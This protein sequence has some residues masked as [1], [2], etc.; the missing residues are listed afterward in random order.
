MINKELKAELFMLQTTSIERLSTGKAPHVFYVKPM[1][2]QRI[3][4][5]VLKFDAQQDNLVSIVI[6]NTHPA[7]NTQGGVFINPNKQAAVSSAHQYNQ[8]HAFGLCSQ[9]QPLTSSFD[10]NISNCFFMDWRL[11]CFTSLPTFLKWSCRGN[12]AYA[13]ISCT[14]L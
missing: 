9:S 14:D 12:K 3:T 13:D 7:V 2:A 6:M 11:L 4:K 10:L 8:L 1:A 5:T